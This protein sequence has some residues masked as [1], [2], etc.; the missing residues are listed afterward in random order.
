MCSKK[1][2]INMEKF[3]E[4]INGLYNGNFE[5]VREI[6]KDNL[7][8]NPKNL[9]M[10]ALDLIFRSNLP[11]FFPTQTNLR[12]L[13]LGC[14]NRYHPDWVNIDIVKTGQNVIQ[15]DLLKGIPFE[16]NSFDVVY[17]SHLL[18][19][20]SKSYAP[21]FIKECFRV[22]KP[23]GIIRVVVPDLEGIVR[24]YLKLLESSLEGDPEAQK[25]YEWIMLELFDQMVRNYSGG[26][27]LDYWL[28]NPMPAENFVIQRIGS[29]VKSI[30]NSLREN[31]AQFLNRKKNINDPLEIGKFRLSGEIH[32]WI[33]DR[34]SLNKLLTEAGFTDF[35]VCKASESR[36]PNFNQ[37]LL[38]IES[39]GSTRKP[40]SLFV[41]AIKPTEEIPKINIKLKEKEKI[42]KPRNKPKV[43]HLS[44]LDTGGAGIAAI[45]LHLGLLNI[46]YDSKFLVLYK[47]TNYPG[48]YS[49]KRK[50]FAENWTWETYINKWN[51][52]LCS[53][54]PNRPK[55]LEIFTH[56]EGITN[57]QEDENII[58]ADIIN[59][60]WIPSMIDFKNDIEILKSKTIVWT[61][62]DENPYTGGCHYT[63]GCERFKNECFSCPQLKSNIQYDL[64]HFQFKIK[65][66]FFESMNP[67]LVCPSKWLA[68]R[69][70]LSKL[71]QNKS[72]FVIPNGIPTS[73]FHKY[74]LAAIRKELQIPENSLIILFGSDYQTKRKG[75]YFISEILE[76]L[77]KIIN[78]KNVYVLTFGTYLNF[79][80]KSGIPIIHL[81]YI[82]NPNFLAMVYSMSDIY[83]NLSIEDNLPNTIIESICCGTPTVAFNVGGIPDIIEHQKNGWLAKPFDLTQIIEG[84]YFWGNKTNINKD[85]ISYEAKQ[86][87]DIS[88]QA[89][90]YDKLY[91]QKF[92]EL[93]EV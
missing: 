10:K 53:K 24:E 39:D 64:S 11:E 70:K 54:Y 66:K 69:A 12:M 46:G 22:L 85:E 31:P 56:I 23:G 68:Q 45:R 76:K 86:R 43:V 35:K 89:A 48:I 77:P 92:L 62:H 40:D 63:S 73:I 59:F 44:V 55:D 84:I 79:R 1:E 7:K 15:Y 9:E 71:L 74:D 67:R 65:E 19:H 30:L 5:V 25:R 91:N 49:I 57:L 16:D 42:F 33:Y 93:N 50:K 87:F 51:T 37:Y 27:M 18:E 78:G 52:F 34:Y 47:N 61:M 14:G 72:I 82:K 81:G 88:V 8:I 58:N 38:D 29:E 80:S 60:H 36:I 32:Q 20:F 17:H 83:L 13:N 41:E 6:I 2:R 90:N 3:E 28:Q 75:S 26:E 21:F 4:L